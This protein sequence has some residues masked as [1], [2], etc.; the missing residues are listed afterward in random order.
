[1]TF[2][3][4]RGPFQVSWDNQLVPGAR[5]EMNGAI[6]THR[7]GLA[8]GL[9]CLGRWDH[10][11]V[12]G[13]SS[14]GPK[15]GDS[16][17]LSGPAE[18][19]TNSEICPFLSFAT[20]KRNVLKRIKKS[21]YNHKKAAM[22]VDTRYKQCNLYITDI[23]L[24][25]CGNCPSTWPY[26][27]PFVIRTFCDAVGNR[28]RPNDARNFAAPNWELKTQTLSIAS[29]LQRL[30]AG[31][32]ELHSSF[33]DSLLFGRHQLDKQKTKNK[34]AKLVFKSKHWS[35]HPHLAERIHR[36][37]DIV[38]VNTT[39]IWLHSYL[40]GDF[41]RIFFGRTKNVRCT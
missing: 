26:S 15:R 37:F 13:K 6:C 8:Q 29:P 21:C 31:P 28:H 18:T 25:G 11:K 35:R 27:I 32:N 17:T 40:A 34:L 12:G 16:P 22:D 20:K 36:H 7:Q 39:F 2:Q 3:P 4:F 23:V 14:F 1:M 10:G 38:E 33:L 41:R 9:W 30:S 24:C 19:A 5:F